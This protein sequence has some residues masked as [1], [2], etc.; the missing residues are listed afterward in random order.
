MRRGEVEAVTGGSFRLAFDLIHHTEGVEMSA[1]QII[2]PLTLKSG[3]TTVAFE[4]NNQILRDAIAKRGFPA[5]PEGVLSI[6]GIRGAVPYT[7]SPP[8]VHLLTLKDN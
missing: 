7:N 2:I 4:V 5:A 1:S 3:R 8:G 6:F